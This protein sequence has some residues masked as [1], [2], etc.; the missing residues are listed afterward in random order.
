M[1][2]GFAA[3]LQ[4]LADRMGE[5]VG[6]GGD[7]LNSSDQN[8]GK[9]DVVAWKHFADGRAGKLIAFGQCA[10]GANWRDKLSD[11]HDT[12]GW[13]QKWL[14]HVPLVGPVRLFFVPHRI[15]RD[16]WPSTT[17]DAGVI[18][19]RCRI[20]QYSSGLPSDI[21]DEC[22]AWNAHVVASSLLAPP[23]TL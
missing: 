10:T 15:P 14:R 11:I 21:L 2:P 1:P 20:A 4:V 19:D 18:F 5:G 23:E 17:I 3:A 13:C 16:L 6:P 9:L 22:R 8:D 12:R 7:A